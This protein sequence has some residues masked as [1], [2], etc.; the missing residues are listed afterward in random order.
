MDDLPS[1][2]IHEVLDYLSFTEQRVCYLASTVFHV[3]TDKS[4]CDTVITQ[5]KERPLTRSIQSGYYDTFLLDLPKDKLIEII[6]RLTDDKAAFSANWLNENTK[7]FGEWILRSTVYQKQYHTN[8]L[9]HCQECDKM[10]S[11]CYGNDVYYGE[12]AFT[13]RSCGVCNTQGCFRPH[14]DWIGCMNAILMRCEDG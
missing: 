3:L 7:E 10:R 5:Y 4:V 1:E 2:L 6:K 14:G 9:F 8:N 13:Y 11:R 12:L